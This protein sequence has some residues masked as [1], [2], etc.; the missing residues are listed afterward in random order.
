MTYFLDSTIHTSTCSVGTY[1]LALLYRFHVQRK[2]EPKETIFVHI[3]CA[4][5]P[6]CLAVR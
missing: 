6:I 1:V 2:K 4:Y 3:R 5:S